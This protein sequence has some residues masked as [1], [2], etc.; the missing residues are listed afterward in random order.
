MPV[1]DDPNYADYLQEADDNYKANRF[2]DSAAM[3][4]HLMELSIRH[5]DPHKA[6]Y[7]GFR[8]IDAWEREKNRLRV[9]RIYHDLGRLSF[10]QALHNSQAVATKTKNKKERIEALRLMASILQVWDP[11]KRVFAIKDL[12][13]LNLELSEEKDRPL[14][15]RRAILTETAEIV[16]DLGDEDL[17]NRVKRRLAQIHIEVGQDA[18]EKN[19]LDTEHVAAREYEKAAKLYQEIGDEKTAKALLQKSKDLLGKK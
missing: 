16:K 10:S 7:F 1:E 6:L 9:A 5:K 8:A 2:R 19:G 13:K 18:L 12:V 15:E 14:T 3:Y 11:E 4:E 17:L